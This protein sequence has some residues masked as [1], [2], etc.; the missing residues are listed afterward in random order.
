MYINRNTKIMLWACAFLFVLG[1][2]FRLMDTR[3]VNLPLRLSAISYL[4]YCVLCMV[5]LIFLNRDIPNNHSRRFLM[6]GV[7]LL[8]AW[9]IVGM[10]RDVLYPDSFAINRWLWYLYYVP[11]LFM[12]TVFF[13]AAQNMGLH[14]SQKIKPHW[15]ITLLISGVLAALVLTN[16]YHRQA[17]SFPE[18]LENYNVSKEYGPLFYIVM[19]WVFALFGMICLTLWN[20][21]KV[22]KNRTYIW[23]V[24]VGI[25]LGGLYLVWRITNYRVIPWLNDMYDIPQIWEAIVLLAIEFGVR[26][27]IIRAN[28]N[29]PEFYMA[30]TISSSLVDADGTVRYQ[31]SGIIPSTEAQRLES[32]EHS[33]Y[34][35]RDHRLGGRHISG[36]FAFWTDDLSQFNELSQKLVEI[37]EHLKEENNLIKA[38]N[39]IIA[40]RSKADERNKLYDL[41]AKSV[42]PE[43]DII[44]DLIKNTSPDRPDFNE[45]LSEACVH[46]AYI[47]RYCN[48]TLLSQDTKELSSFELENSIKESMQYIRLRGIECDYMK[49]GEGFYP[50]EALLLAYAMFERAVVRADKPES[51]A[52]EV[53]AN[54]RALRL[55]V[56]IIGDETLTLTTADFDDFDEKLKEIGGSRRFRMEEKEKILRVDIPKKIGG[57]AL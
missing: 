34:V 49:F 18:G 1:G 2:I 22:E 42:S 40:R 23:V 4:A 15:Y 33:V 45:R 14:N 47:K 29:F 21:I 31:T 28:F 32:L 11:M 27:G 3:L 7:F 13:L 35:D 50:A 25:G 36:G 10:I 53:L 17:F 20:R 55:S 24:F 57:E 38:E 8:L 48:M 39:E 19:I 52:V 54:E 56:H 44:E 26:L 37:Q 46:K 9:Q 16:D 5:C 30:S 6:T 51:I 41:M 12:P 43:L